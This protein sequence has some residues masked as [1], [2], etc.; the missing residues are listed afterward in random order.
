MKSN[1]YFAAILIGVAVIL[2]ALH[3][4]LLS[5]RIED[6]RS[7]ITMQSKVIEAMI[8]ELE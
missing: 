7:V 1:T 5:K 3:C 6:N 2:N 4:I 8:K